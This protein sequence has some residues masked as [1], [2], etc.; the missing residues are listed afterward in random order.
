[1]F[2]IIACQAGLF[3]CIAGLFQ[4]FF[5]F[6]FYG[7]GDEISGKDLLLGFAGL[8][9]VDIISAVFLSLIGQVPDQ[10]KEFDPHLLGS[11]IYLF[12]FTVA[13]LGPI[14]E[15]II[16][17]GYILGMLVKPDS[18]ILKN[19]LPIIFSSLL[20]MAA[21]LDDISENFFIG[22]P[23]F[24]LGVY[25]SFWAIRKKGVMLPI[26]LHITQNFMAALAMMYQLKQ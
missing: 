19:I 4:I 8:I 10:F 1:M 24:L 9:G 16:F 13:L 2:I 11:N 7:F 26:L 12:M 23:L 17:R 14:Y 22:V 6:D 18:E 25:F 20:F 15:E 3:L 5:K 21:H